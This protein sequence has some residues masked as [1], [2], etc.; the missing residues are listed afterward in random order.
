MT[1]DDVLDA[2]NKP[3]YTLFEP[4]DRADRLADPE[5]A[6][7]EF[8]GR[9]DSRSTPLPS[10]D[11]RYDKYRLLEGGYLLLTVKP[12]AVSGRWLVSAKLVWSIWDREV[13]DSHWSFCEGEEPF[14]PSV[15]AE[16]AAAI[17]KRYPLPAAALPSPPP[18]ERVRKRRM[19]FE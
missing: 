9:Y 5:Y 3:L 16:L 2:L 14:S 18:K 1:A 13:V 19:V 6:F 10:T 8:V 11:E 15:L 4:Y 17:A 7:C 12:S